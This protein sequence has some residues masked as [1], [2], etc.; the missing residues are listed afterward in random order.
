MKRI[1]LIH[2]NESSASVSDLQQLLVAMEMGFEIEAEERNSQT[3]GK[4]TYAAVR[5]LQKTFQI[6]FD[7]KTLVDAP[8]AELLNGLLDGLG[9]N[10][11][12]Y[13]VS[14]VVYR[15][16]EIL[17]GVLI[18]AF[19]QDLPSKKTPRAQLGK[20]VISD[21]KGFYR[22]PYTA[23]EFKEAERKSADIL[24]TVSTRDGKLLHESKVLYNAAARTV[25]DIYID[26]EDNSKQ[27]SEFDRYT[28]ILMPLLANELSLAELT[29][30]DIDF[31]K[32]ET[33]ISASRIHLLKTAHHWEAAFFR[34]QVPAAFMY[35]ILR[36]GY[37][38]I[39]ALWAQKSTDALAEA[40]KISAEELITPAF[41]EEEMKKFIS[42]VLHT[43]TEQALQQDDRE[44][45]ASLTTI[46][47]AVLPE[48]DRQFSFLNRY[49]EMQDNLE[50]FW[51]SIA[52]DADFSAEVPR[53]KFI[54]QLAAISSNNTTLIQALLKN[55]LEQL[56]DLT[57]LTSDDWEKL[58][59]ENSVGIPTQIMGDGDEQIG[60]YAASLRAMLERELPN[61]YI[62]QTFQE[63][64]NNPLHKDIHVFIDQATHFSFT[65]Q[66]LDEYLKTEEGNI[67][68]KQL[69]DP[70]KTVQQLRSIQRIYNLT[71]E[72][73]SMQVLLGN[74]LTSAWQI[75][76]IPPAQ[77]MHLLNGELNTQ[78]VLAIQAKATA[79]T[80]QVAMSYLDFA[81]IAKQRLPFVLSGG[82]SQE[83]IIKDIPDY[84]KLFG[85][86]DLCSCG[87][88]RSVYSPT[89]YFVS[90]LNDLL[91]G[92]FI[93]KN[94][95]LGKPAVEL[96]KRRPDL[97][98]LKLS[99]QNTETEIPYIDL[100]NEILETYIAIGTLNEA[101]TR[102]SSP[103]TAEELAANPQFMIEEAYEKLKEAIYPLQL[104]FDLNLET[105]RQFLDY[106]GKTRYELIKTFKKDDAVSV[107]SSISAEYLN[108]SETEYALLTG[109]DLAGNDQ[110]FSPISL[111]GY[112]D[113][114][115]ALGDTSRLRNVQNLIGRLS[116]SFNE[117]TEILKTSFINPYG[118]ILAF[119]QDHPD[120]SHPELDPLIDDIETSTIVL[121]SPEDALCDL[122]QTTIVYKNGA[123]IDDADYAKLN[124]FVRLWKKTGYSVAELDLLLINLSDSSPATMSPKTL[125]QMVD[126]IVLQRQLRISIDELVCI[127]GHIDTRST[128]SLY[129]KL[130]LSKAALKIDE[131]LVLNSSRTELADTALSMSDHIPALLAAFRIS[132]TAL[133][134][135]QAHAFPNNADILLS[136]SSIS[137]L[138]RYTVLAK[139]L[140][141][142]V[143]DLIS[144]LN[145]S[146]SNDPFISPVATE[147]FLKLV[148]DI[149]TS[150][151]KLNQLDYLYRHS[152]S[153]IPLFDL[154]LVQQHQLVKSI[155]EGLLAIDTIQNQSAIPSLQDLS[156][157]L[158]KI[159][160]GKLVEQVI[161]T[162]DGTF[163]YQVN[164][165]VLPNPI[166]EELAGKC[167]YDASAKTLQC[168]GVLRTDERDTLKNIAPGDIALTEAVDQLYTMPGAFFAMLFYGFL[169]AQHVQE[170][171]FEQSLPGGEILTTTE[172]RLSYFMLKLAPFLKTRLSSIFCRQLLSDTLKTDTTL[173]DLIF[174]RILPQ[175]ESAILAL[176]QGGTDETYSD[177][178]QL[179]RSMAMLLAPT[180]EEFTFYATSEQGV[181]LWLDDQLIIDEWS[182]TVPATFHTKIK[183]KAGQLY[184]LQMEYYQDNAINT[185]QIQW[186]SPTIPKQTVPDKQLFAISLIENFVST[187]HRCAKIT[188]LIAGFKLDT[189]ELH[190]FISYASDFDGFDLALLPTS[191]NQAYNE[192]PFKQWQRI[193][194]YCNLRDSL[195]GTAAHN[196]ITIFRA[197]GFDFD[198]LLKEVIASTGWDEKAMQLLMGTAY[199]TGFFEAPASAYRNEKL[200][201]LMQQ[202][203]LLESSL[204]IS[205]QKLALW[206]TTTPDAAQARDI[207]NTVKA[208]YEDADWLLVAKEVNNK[209]RVLQRKALVSYLLS[210]QDMKDKNIHDSND[211]YQ[212]FLIDVEMEACMLTSRIVQANASVQLFVQRCLMNL[213]PSIIPAAIDA[214]HWSWMKKYRVWEANRK[215]F[216]YPE[217]WIE[218]EL[219][220]SK[221]PIFKELE[222]KL[223]QGEVTDAH[224]E[225]AVLQYLAELDTI[226]RLDI[227]AMYQDDEGHILHVFGRTFNMPFKYYYRSYNT[228][229]NIWTP[230]DKLQ[231]DIEGGHLLP[232]VWNRRLYLFWT[233]FTEKARPQ[234]GQAKLSGAA[235]DTYYEIKLAWSEYRQGNW[236]PKML[237]E[238]FLEAPI[239]EGFA[240]FSP[241]EVITLRSLVNTAA[242]TLTVRFFSL[243]LARYQ[244]PLGDFIFDG[245]NASP[246]ISLAMNQVPPAVHLTGTYIRNVAFEETNNVSDSANNRLL[247]FKGNISMGVASPE[248]DFDSKKKDFPVLETTPGNFQ[249][250][251]SGQGQQFSI[252]RPFFFQDSKR[253]YFVVPYS[254][255]M[256]FIEAVL[257]KDTPKLPEYLEHKDYIPWKDD[258]RPIDRVIKW[259]D[260]IPY[261]MVGEPVLNLNSSLNKY[262]HVISAERPAVQPRMLATGQ[263]AAEQ[264]IAVA[265]YYT[266][267]NASVIG[268]YQWK[269]SQQFYGFR[270]YNFFHAFVCPFVRTVNKEGIDGLLTVTNQKYGELTAQYEPK[271]DNATVFKSSY[272][273]TALVA[274]PY[275]HELVDFSESGAYSIYNWELFFHI[276]MLMANR[277]SKNQ[278]FEEAMR[279]YHYI[280]DPTS[281]QNESSPK[282]YWNLLP[283]KTTPQESIQQLLAKLQ[284]ADGNPAKESLV[285]QIKQWKDNPFNPHLIARK[286]LMAYMKNV[287]MKYLDNLLAWG[288]F[289]FAQDSM[290]SVAEAA[291]IYVLAAEI[292]G[293]RPA[294]IPP[295]VKSPTE[296]YESLRPKLDAFDNAMV[297]METMFPYYSD[298]SVPNGVD[299]QVPQLT[300]IAQAS[301][302][303]IPENDKLLGYWD[304]VND[305]LFKIRHCQNL[306]G[307]ERK[308]SLFEPPIDPALLV[309]A[310][311]S[312]ID[313][314]SVLSDLHAPLP[315][316]RFS[317][318]VQKAQEM[319]GELK[320][321]ASALLAALEKK[322]AEEL[323]MIKATQETS[324]L[325]QMRELKKF[326]YQEAVISRENILKTRETTV[327]RWRHYKTLLGEENPEEPAIGANIAETTLPQD[328]SSN[329]EGRKVSSYEAHE[330]NKSAD[331]ASSQSTAS[332]WELWSSVAH[333][334]P[335]FN[336]EPWGLGTTFGGSNVGSALGAVAKQYQNDAAESNVVAAKASKL[337][338][339]FRREQDWILQCNTATKEI[340]A[341][342]KQLSAAEIRIDIALKDQENHEQQIK[343]AHNTED[344]MRNKYTKAELYGWLQ[345]E[346][347]TV[348]FQAYQLAYDLARKAEKCYRFERGLSNSNFIQF[349]YWDSFRKG[350][351]AGERLS[352]AL[353]QLEKAYTEGN[354]REY[355]LTKHIS[356]LQLAPD[357]LLEL[358]RK[359]TCELQLP[360]WLFD[361]DYPGHY[362]RRIKSVSLT[363]PCI[364]GPYTSV[365]CTLSLLSS[366][367]RTDHTGNY[368]KGENDSRFL[369]NYGSLQSIATSSAQNDSGLFEVNFRDERYLP[370]EGQGAVSRWKLDMPMQSN[371]FDFNTVTDVILHLKYTA[372]DGGNT[373][374]SKV[375]SYLQASLPLGGMALFSLKHDFPDDWYTFISQLDDE[376]LKNFRASLTDNRFPFRFRGKLNDLTFSD[377]LLVVLPKASIELSPKHPKFGNVAI[378]H[379]IQLVD[380]QIMMDETTMSS[381][382]SMLLKDGLD[383]LDPSKVEDLFV[384]FTYSL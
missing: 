199:G 104:P 4:S 68:L 264:V 73:S 16:R 286:R 174:Q 276:P 202:C 146:P 192:Q 205:V 329:A 2:L 223:L 13:E 121:S 48:Q 96:F 334:V 237:S 111:Y 331:A 46:L 179:G 332:D 209:L 282:R 34:D 84:A 178:D 126:A 243:T 158:G 221:S 92:K 265:D 110:V 236:K 131:Q 321:M 229:T 357:A 268:R 149:K 107:I 346:I 43:A 320:S 227:R 29:A 251:A 298:Q 290:E 114:S 155:R 317:F 160:E 275:P 24:L 173:I 109:K 273:P 182:N 137:K 316:Y 51:E 311:A 175:M 260:P 112:P 295:R 32:N 159:F 365:N 314:G 381:L 22:I 327:Q 61:T 98:Y 65:K 20:P 142:T 352:L 310:V 219:R 38:G 299:S 101:H 235:P 269:K 33:A 81:D 259:T 83:E 187:Y 343:N 283:F 312:G 248:T 78:Q 274:K 206:A 258:P 86:F 238:S 201:A 344:F 102:D 252:D 324:L 128:S 190:Y 115:V 287:V 291:H 240:G 200:L 161:G 30:A 279:W 181:R 211:L 253:S 12:G 106:Q 233:V 144:L 306:A 25:V 18:T 55:G 372:R 113:D 57:K 47:S 350:L 52:K 382:P 256:F 139:I 378:S 300:S 134:A 216:L 130:F 360:E 270:F 328:Q 305:R 359:G 3:A 67:A 368:E 100:V 165:D 313:I 234:N 193:N 226:S 150:P 169:E 87:H 132:E 366:E 153:S 118:H 330:L 145:L 6:Q 370:F 135:I 326:Q 21:S 177:T 54:L 208:K 301:Y 62:R 247:V 278:R 35:G 23:D 353:K 189:E 198:V 176:Q 347:S 9:F 14:G 97:K 308:L 188:S 228:A 280:F 285:N 213:E 56:D 257:V 15:H 262:S 197:A 59:R 231:V 284:L 191:S 266:N 371:S 345:G 171:L 272:N 17:P 28:T 82:V 77:L 120:E 162:L 376:A 116:I 294:S 355:E 241:K 230:W 337:G 76:S 281:V 375:N 249:V 119:L 374:R 66:A 117:L 157:Q 44:G 151:F 53:L 40:A 108:L 167:T 138:Y 93:G 5:R 42:I 358:K 338:N 203:I 143:Q 302:F 293:K 288:D 297:N 125:Q 289:L 379:A 340:M 19:D 380:Q 246:K 164:L 292:L 242:N 148:A 333:A 123:P 225:E 215:V 351:M 373:L 363:I 103:F 362:L 127:W 348:Y 318:V 70:D 91:G 239:I 383:R 152:S 356:L 244:W 267:L 354:T 222:N 384:L 49:R 31:L 7:E 185:S 156:Q 95:N 220:D 50:L 60:N 8:T 304:L 315:A 75:A 271:D 245:C 11:E 254:Y 141:I 277:L 41:S 218:P 140:K 1:N 204:G 232:V 195:R 341:I 105:A 94:A 186:S 63:T 377:A 147:K 74:G 69:A 71:G 309:Q 339:Y 72:A 325:N 349:G 124:R 296:T 364:A 183:L 10:D 263:T 88:C 367:I 122:S 79:V 27:L 323:S 194:A 319:C 307:A 212:Y 196:L 58:I 85:S 336:I 303:C 170:L 166:P 172:E 39:L 36:Q 255:N 210:Q 129:Q 250:L 37:P 45:E 64:A 163:P 133:L 154:G 80:S 361:M 342:D 136:V 180:S 335:N 369:T 261:E 322:D 224:A 214:D 168:K 26:P 217:N 184:R 207:K 90:L 99:C 89:A